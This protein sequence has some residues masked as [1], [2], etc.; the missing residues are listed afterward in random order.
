MKRYLSKFEGCSDQRLGE[1]LYECTMNGWCDDEFGDVDTCGWHGFIYR[2]K[3]K[4]S[5][6]V[7]ED[8]QGFFDYEDLP[9]SQAEK[10]WNA[11]RLEVEPLEEEAP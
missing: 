10:L 1:R 3:R 8:S 5:Y 2:P 7:Y 11:F 9:S 4:L 6:V